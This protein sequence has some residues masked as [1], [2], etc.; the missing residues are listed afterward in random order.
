MCAK[1]LNLSSSNGAAAHRSV[2]H[3][4]KNIATNEAARKVKW[5][6]GTA[7]HTRQPDNS[8]GEKVSK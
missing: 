1:I 5:A 3:T 6:H 4:Y 7:V 2:L 8:K